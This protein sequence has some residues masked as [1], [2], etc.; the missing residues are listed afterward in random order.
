MPGR[1]RLLG[2]GSGAGLCPPSNSPPGGGSPDPVHHGLAEGSDRLAGG[3]PHGLGWK[4]KS[5]LS[6]ARRDKSA[7]AVFI[8]Q[9]A[10][11]NFLGPRRAMLLNN[12]LTKSNLVSP[13][14]QPRSA[15]PVGRR[16]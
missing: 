7:L 8:T 3:A 13:A 16:V 4:H 2:P 9:A 15:A 10:K 12:L 1:G 6:I 11:P 5:R 14:A